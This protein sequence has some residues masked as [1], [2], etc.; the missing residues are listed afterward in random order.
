MII[1]GVLTILF[2][3]YLTSSYSPL[4]RNLPLDLAL[5]LSDEDREGDVVTSA[6]RKQIQRIKQALDPLAKVKGVGEASVAKI[7]GAGDA[8]FRNPKSKC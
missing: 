5:E 8:V 6:E 1:L 2:H 3:V 7:R 4:I